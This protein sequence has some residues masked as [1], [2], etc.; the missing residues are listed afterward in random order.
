MDKIPR[1]QTTDLQ[2]PYDYYSIMHYDNQAFSKNGQPTMIPKQ[3]GVDIG[4]YPR[5]TP[6]DIYEVRRFYGCQ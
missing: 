5:L 6:T 1:D 2:T 4:V 3:Q